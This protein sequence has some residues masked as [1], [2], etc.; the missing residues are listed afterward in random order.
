M[1]NLIYWPK[2]YVSISFPQHLLKIRY[3]C[4]SAISATGA[5]SNFRFGECLLFTRVVYCMEK[6]FSKHF[7]RWQ[8][9]DINGRS[10]NPFTWPWQFF[11]LTEKKRTRDH[12]FAYVACIFRVKWCT[13][14]MHNA[15]ARTVLET[16]SSGDVLLGKE[17]LYC[18]NESFG[19]KNL[20]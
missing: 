10:R 8:I 5:L 20:I 16:N 18:Y 4:V 12:P 14:G 1:Y 2:K 17:K 7:A 19:S 15:M 13:G 3:K 9:R 6:I 11:F